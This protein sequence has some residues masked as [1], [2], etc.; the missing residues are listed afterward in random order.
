[1]GIPF[2]DLQDGARVTSK[3]SLNSIRGMTYD[4][5]V[6]HGLVLLLHETLCHKIYLGVHFCTRCG[7]E[8]VNVSLTVTFDGFDC[9]FSLFQIEIR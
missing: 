7:R 5:Q 8:L 1:M 4:I 6:G 9:A 2:T 3:G